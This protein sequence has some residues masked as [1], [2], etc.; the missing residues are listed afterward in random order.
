[1]TEGHCHLSLLASPGYRRITGTDEDRV[2]DDGRSTDRTNRCGEGWV[3]VEKVQMCDFGVTGLSQSVSYNVA[4]GLL[5][6]FGKLV[7]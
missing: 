3:K 6:L 4:F 7:I 2:E 1:M 5:F